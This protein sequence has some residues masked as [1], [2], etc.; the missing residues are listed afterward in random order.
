[1]FYPTQEQLGT[2]ANW[3][4]HFIWIFIGEGNDKTEAGGPKLDDNK[5]IV[6]ILNQNTIDSGCWK[7]WNKFGLVFK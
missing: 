1:M 7:A 6:K 4:C 3:G 5:Y 2:T